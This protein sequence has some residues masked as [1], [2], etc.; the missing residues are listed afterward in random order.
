[1]VDVRDKVTRFDADLVEA[2]AAEGS[3]QSRSARQQLAHWVRVGRAVS[4]VSTS[5]RARVE[6]ALTGER[7]MSTLTREESVVVN[8]E[9][10]VGIEER[11]SRVNFGDELAAEGITTV[12]LD[13]EGNLVEYRPDGTSALLAEL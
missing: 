3:R 11:L 1:M 2:A 5:Q 6:A 7:P 9:I 10:S 4:S 8:A 13:A 12:A